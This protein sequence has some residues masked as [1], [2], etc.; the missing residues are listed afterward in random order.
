MKTPS[1]L[2]AVLP[3]L[4]LAGC[5]SGPSV[6]TDSLLNPLYARYYYQDL[7][8][9]MANYSI[10]KDPMLQDADKKKTVESARE[11]AI[12]HV[13]DANAKINA[14]RRGAFMSDADYATGLALHL[15]GTLYFSQDFNTLPGPEIR[16]YVSDLLDPRGASGALLFPDPSATDLGL[17]RSPYGAQSY[18]LP[19]KAGTAFRSVILWD[20]RLERMMGFAQIGK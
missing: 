17:L 9:T 19:E 2:F 6:S 14:G 4:L 16:V 7:A 8:D 1:A 11:R 3:A 20:R 18:A 13:K 5:G 10:Q 15:D 12:Q